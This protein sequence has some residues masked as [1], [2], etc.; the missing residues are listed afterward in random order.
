MALAGWQ[1]GQLE[2]NLTLVRRAWEE[3]TV[4]LLIVDNLED[5]KL[6]QQWRPLPGGGCRVLITTRR[7][8]WPQRSGVTAVA[9]PLLTSAESYELLLTPR[10]AM[11]QTTVADLLADLT[12]EEAAD[13]ICTAVGG[14]P[15]ALALAAAYLE[16]N[17][18]VSLPRYSATLNAQL[19]AHPSLQADFVDEL[20]T[21]HAPS[22]TAT[23]ALS[24]DRL[25]P[26][27]TTDA[28]ALRL[29]HVAAACAPEPIPRPLLYRAGA[30]DP[31]EPLPPETADPALARLGSLGLLD[32]L[33]DTA[34]RLHR[35]LAAYVRTRSLPGDDAAVILEAALLKEVY[36]IN[37]AGY[38]LAGTPYLPHL[39]YV[40]ALAD[41]RG[42]VN[43]VA[44]LN[45]LA[46]LL[47]NQGDYAASR[48]IYERALEIAE[49]VLGSNHS[50]TASIL[51]NLASLM[52]AQGDYVAAR[53]LLEHA[54]AIQEATLGPTHP[55]TASSLNNLAAL[56]YAQGEYSASRP[57]LERA[58]AIAEVALGPAHPD[59]ALSLNNLA[60]LLEAQ[61]DYA[62]AQFLY[63]R[64]LAIYEAVLGP[65]HP[66]TASS[67][68]NLAELLKEQGDRAAAR[69]LLERALTIREVSLG[70]SHPQTAMS[71]NNLAALLRAQGDYTA[72]RPLYERALAIMEQALGPDHLNT[73][74]VR[75]NL[76]ALVQEMSAQ[77]T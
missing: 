33:P 70:P 7:G 67:L 29:L 12:I 64:A 52:R 6:W 62:A 54:L 25:D 49:T 69:P 71:L 55:A 9:L 51:N 21:G 61:G 38:P 44:L 66:A 58:L 56:L 59:T 3:P 72:A 77:T 23:F 40:A 15:L 31:A 75:S 47:Y 24:Y 4:R 17:P 43:A 57:L 28:L 50:T 13:T 1:D 63:E 32:E 73:H 16:E 37:Q 10:A 20:P 27:S 14:L 76:S 53:P 11:K 2:R 19:L 34:L 41:Q 46:D 8:Q 74:T 35:L 22:I 65:T 26:T 42:D 60:G 39:R 36:L 30:D 5:P 68:N 45:N 48:L 18:G